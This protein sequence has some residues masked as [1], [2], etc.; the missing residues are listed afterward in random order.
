MTGPEFAAAHGNDSSTWT[1]ADFETEINLA[2]IDAYRA[3]PTTTDTPN[4]DLAA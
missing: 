4:H 1:T 2:E 3:N